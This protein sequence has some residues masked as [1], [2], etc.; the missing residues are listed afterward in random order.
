MISFTVVMFSL[1]FL[2]DKSIIRGVPD[3]MPLGRI[4]F[5]IL[6]AYVVRIFRILVSPLFCGLE[7]RKNAAK[8]EI[9]YFISI[10]TTFRTPSGGRKFYYFILSKVAAL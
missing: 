2:R 1:L 7:I 5:S 10:F 8:A 4:Y 3:K 6:W 9:F